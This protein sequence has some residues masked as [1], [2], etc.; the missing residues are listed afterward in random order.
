MA[1]TLYISTYN[2]D[3]EFKWVRTFFFWCVSVRIANFRGDLLTFL[4]GVNRLLN[5]P[6]C[7]YVFIKAYIVKSSDNI[8]STPSYIGRSCR[9]Q[10]C[11]DQSIVAP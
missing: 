2:R 10:G 5:G 4:C 8:V 11:I 3:D 1:H 7:G 9:Q 6:D